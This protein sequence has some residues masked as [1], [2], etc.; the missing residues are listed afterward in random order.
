MD[1]GGDVEAGFG[2][3]CGVCGVCVV[4]EGVEV[5][6]DVA[7]G[8]GRACC[9]LGRVESR[10]GEE[11]DS[12]KVAAAF[13]GGGFAVVDFEVADVRMPAEKGDGGVPLHGADCFEDGVVLFGSDDD[14]AK[15]ED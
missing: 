8:E 9:R 6:V 4:A 15:D 14:V 10:D 13:E 3:E 11:A 12:F 5:V 7:A 1:G 2:W